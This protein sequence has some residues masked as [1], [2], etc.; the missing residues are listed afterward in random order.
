MNTEIEDMV[1]E[2][3]IDSNDLAATNTRV[4]DRLQAD[5]EQKPIRVIKSDIGPANEVDVGGSL[6]SEYEGNEQFPDDDPVVQVVFESD[7]NHRVAGWEDHIGS[8]DDYLSEFEDEWG[9]AVNRYNYPQSRMKEISE[10]IAD[11]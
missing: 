3:P 2:N 10:P 11:N 9:V 1:D 7:L 8:L 4:V 5:D 6:V